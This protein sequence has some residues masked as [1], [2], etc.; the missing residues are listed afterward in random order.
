MVERSI[1]DRVLSGL[2]EEAKAR[3]LGDLLDE[4]TTMGAL[5]NEDQM[6]RV[7]GYIDK[8]KKEGARLTVGDWIARKEVPGYRLCKRGF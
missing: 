8:G 6:N 1:K 4:G 2:V 7:F 5:V 3:R